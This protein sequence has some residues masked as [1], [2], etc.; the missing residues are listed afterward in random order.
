MIRTE[1]EKKNGRLVDVAQTSGEIVEWRRLQQ[2][3]LEQTGLAEWERVNSV[4]PSE[5]LVRTPEPH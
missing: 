5:Q 3:N 1:R 2:K 4:Q